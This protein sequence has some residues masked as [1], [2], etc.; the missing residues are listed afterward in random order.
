MTGDLLVYLATFSVLIVPFLLPKMHDRYFF[1]ADVIAVIFAFYFPKYWPIPV[2]IGS[3]SFLAYLPYSY[4]VTP[5]PLPL[6]AVFLLILI[7]VLGRKLLRT[8]NTRPYGCDGSKQ[9]SSLISSATAKIMPNVIQDKKRFI[10]L[11][12][13]WFAI[14]LL[15]LI[16]RLLGISFISWD[17]IIFLSSWYNIIVDDGFASL[18]RGFSNYNVPYLYLLSLASI[19]LP[20]I[21][22]LVAV[23][24][25]SI[26]FDFTLAF[27]VYKCVAFKYSRTET[28]PLLA[29]LVTLLLPSVILNGSVWGQSDSIY[30]AF[31]VACLYALL[32]RRQA[33]AF[34]AFG[35]SFAFK[36]QAV[37]LAPLFLWMLMKKQVNWRYFFLS[38]L[39]YLVT[40]IPAWL[41][42]RPLREL[43]LIY[44]YQGAEY[45]RL[46]ERA[47][48]L[49]QWIPNQYYSWYPLGIVFTALVVLVIA[50]LVFKSRVN[51][52]GDLLVYL[53]T[54]SVVIVPFLL[55][56]MHDRFFFS[57][58]VI[59]V[60]FAF[61]FP[62]YWPTPVVIG[63]VSVLAYLPFLYEITPVPLP[64]LAVFLLI[65]IVV[66]GRKL[67][68]TL[69]IGTPPANTLPTLTAGGARPG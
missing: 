46:S 50:L 15:G 34:I 26:I 2:V 43:L 33:W 44:I 37:F 65:L 29:A 38:P 69:N 56:K 35:L 6:L 25:I 17:Y 20:N 3:V 64:L 28:V 40:L 55:P 9:N 61:Y 36:L 8:L 42:G 51:M 24:A 12:F 59:A 63:S 57:A 5:V 13:I 45:P 39:V 19:L 67:L 22:A 62:K 66:L 47:P 4:E 68:R 14:L 18:Q 60:I 23:K 31:L 21:S 7:V 48:N 49:Y 58:D 11:S 54:F 30:T 41:L 16:V 32:R 27:F 1:P 10:K 53:A 52:T